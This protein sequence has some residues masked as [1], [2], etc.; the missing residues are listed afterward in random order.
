[1]EVTDEADRLVA[2]G[3]LRLANLESADRLA[4][5]RSSP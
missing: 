1:V 3:E 2:R 5:G 4:G